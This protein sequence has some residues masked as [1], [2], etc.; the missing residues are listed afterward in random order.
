MRYAHWRA[1]SERRQKPITIT[2]YFERR[3]TYNLPVAAA[4]CAMQEANNGLLGRATE[5]FAR[6][7]M[8]AL[9]VPSPQVEQ[10]S[11]DLVSAK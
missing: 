9:R 5:A 1:S 4:A 10:G 3:R 6:A 8:D 11:G 2:T 7:Q